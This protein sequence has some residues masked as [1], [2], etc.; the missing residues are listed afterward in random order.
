MAG[1]ALMERAAPQGAPT[2][3]PAPSPE[4]ELEQLMRD[5]G[6][7]GNDISEGMAHVWKAMPT[8]A[9]GE[10]IDHVSGRLGIPAPWDPNAAPVLPQER[11]PLAAVR[12]PPPPELPGPPQR[13]GQPVMPNALMRRAR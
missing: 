9:V 12:R 6:Y 11:E 3:E 2:P 5:T 4:M 8:D 13:G 1:N 10:L 7:T